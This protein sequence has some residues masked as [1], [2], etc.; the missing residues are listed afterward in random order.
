M[1][2][3]SQGRLVG[4]SRHLALS[5]PAPGAIMPPRCGLYVVCYAPKQRK[6]KGMT[7]NTS[8]TYA[9]VFE[10]NWMSDQGSVV[11]SGTQQ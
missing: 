9:A 1:P 7:T 8:V 5:L 2:R 6:Q 3:K 4:S 11:T 10:I